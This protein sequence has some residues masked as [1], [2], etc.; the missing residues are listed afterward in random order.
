MF[1]VI[2]EADSLSPINGLRYFSTQ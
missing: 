2:R 1:L